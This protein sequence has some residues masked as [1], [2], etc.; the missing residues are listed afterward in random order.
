MRLTPIDQIG[1][2]QDG[3]RFF[4]EVGNTLRTSAVLDGALDY[5]AKIIWRYS[6]C[7]TAEP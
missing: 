3:E 7:S 1:V 5:L 2:G 6:Y 4:P